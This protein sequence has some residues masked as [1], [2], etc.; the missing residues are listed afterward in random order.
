MA[1][2]ARLGNDTLELFDLVFGPVVGAE[3]VFKSDLP[4][5]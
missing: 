2:P 4:L 3:L 5:P 1:S